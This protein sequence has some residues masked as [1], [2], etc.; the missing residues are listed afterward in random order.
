MQN[1]STS[2]YTNTNK[3]DKG[4]CEYKCECKHKFEYKRKEKR[5]GI[6][7]CKCDCRRKRLCESK[8]KIDFK[9]IRT[10][11]PKANARLRPTRGL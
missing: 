2:A 4:D 1:Q 10:Y 9:H 3:G 6:Y 11:E 8:R 5:I 7:K